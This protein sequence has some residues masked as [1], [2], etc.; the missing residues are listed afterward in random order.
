MRL[1]D[2]VVV[3]AQGPERLNVAD[4]SIGIVNI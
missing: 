2:I 1:E 3:T 4:H